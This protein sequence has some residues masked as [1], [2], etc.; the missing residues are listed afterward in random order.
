MKK[1]LKWTV[2]VL[3][4]IFACLQFIRPIRNNPPID[5]SKT[6]EARINV[7]PEIDSIFKRSCNDCH[8]SKTD[9]VWYSN[10][11]PVSWHMSKHVEEGR[12][13]L[14]F[15]EWGAYTPKRAEHKLEEIC[16]QVEGNEMPLWD[17]VLLHPSARLSDADKKLIC[18][19]TD[20]ERAKINLDLTAPAN[21]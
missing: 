9:W 6:I 21:K 12:A 7:P 20:A 8:S 10:V 16:E 18:D 11:A 1:A 5:E 3:A 13:E 4:V 19:W 2:I 14:S 17:Y 15:S